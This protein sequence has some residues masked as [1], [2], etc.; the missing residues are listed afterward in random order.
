MPLD[1][2]NPAQQAQQLQM[3]N[4]NNS[5][6]LRKYGIEALVQV[7]STTIAAPTAG[8]NVV[9][10]VPRN[11]GFLKGF[12]VEIT[13]TVN[14]TAAG[15]LTLTPFGPAN[16]L[17]Q[18]LFQDL[19]NNVRIQTAG[20]HMTA[21]ASAKRNWVYGGAF[22]SDTPLGYGSNFAVVVAPA[23]ITAAV[24]AT[25]VRMF[26]Y[27]PVTYSDDDLRGGIYMNVVNATALLQ[28]TINTNAV[29]QAAATDTS[30]QV[31]TGNAA[32]TL[33]G[34]NIIVY[35][36]YIDQVPIGKGG[37]VLPPLDISTIYELKNTTL[38]GLVANQDFPIPFANFRDFMS[39]CIVYDNQA[40]GVIPGNAT[41]PKTFGTADINYFS[42]QS[43]N[44]TNIWK[45][46]TIVAALRTRN[47]LGDDVP[48][49]MYYFDHRRKP[50][51]TVQYGN[52]QINLNPSLVNA[53]AACL[54][55]FEDLAIINQVTGAGSLPAS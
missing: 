6:M 33:T 24:N 22:T 32:A 26:Y 23:T 35:Q 41:T 2:N 19:S 37:P 39:T 7:F 28:L 14:N 51:S 31:Y 45:F 9:N 8:T 50:V 16:L 12:L 11:V 43:A 38:S 13:A 27:V 30:L 5:A 15:A 34:V 53:Q 48:P 1:G 44:F 10:V 18:I 3:L 21:V 55:G 20:W 47:I 25:L 40:A 42:L 52:M 36:S 4:D 49:S 17:Q 46:D 29:N 54:I